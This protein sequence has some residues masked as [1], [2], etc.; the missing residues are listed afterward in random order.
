MDEAHKRL[1]V[2]RLTQDGGFPGPAINPAYYAMLNAARAALSGKDLFAKT[3]PGTWTLFRREFAR[4]GR[5]EA[6]LV[7]PVEEIRKQRIEADCNARDVEPQRAKEILDQA[8]RFVES[9]ATM[10]ESSE[11]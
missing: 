2:A 10:I 5:F 3:H 1:R 11:R 6:A 7:E 8:E 9:V 4:T